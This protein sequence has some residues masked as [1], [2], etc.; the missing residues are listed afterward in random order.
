MRGP[1]RAKETS[2]AEFQIG[3]EATYMSQSG[4]AV[5][6]FRQQNDLAAQFSE[7]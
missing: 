6:I 7:I 1:K 5:R 4:T 3:K 2:R